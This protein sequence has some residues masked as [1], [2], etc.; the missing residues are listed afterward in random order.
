MHVTRIKQIVCVQSFSKDSSF[1]FKL[2][3]LTNAVLINIDYRLDSIYSPPED[4][5]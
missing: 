5:L 3:Y 4:K 1:V 2:K